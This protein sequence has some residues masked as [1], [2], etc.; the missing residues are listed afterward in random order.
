[1]KERTH[2]I[3]NYEK[4]VVKT[5]RLDVL[6]HELKITECDLL[7]I[8]VEGAEYLVLVGLGQRLSTV[9]KIIYETSEKDCC[10]PLLKSFGFDIVHAF[11]M[12]G[13]KYKIAINQQH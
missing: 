9:K 12:S 4:I 8:Y 5:R 3:G 13:S 1:M 11:N 10:E 2:A 7:K 6:F